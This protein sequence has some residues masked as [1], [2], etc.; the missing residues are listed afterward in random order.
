MAFIVQ[1]G[2]DIKEGKTGEFVEW[3]N[4][5]EK[6]L[7][8]AHPAGTKYLGTFFAIYTSEKTAGNAH[9][10]VEME[11]YGSQDALA[12]AGK[13]PDSLYGKLVN[14][15]VSF[16]DQSSNN[17]TQALYKRATAATLWGED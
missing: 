8:N 2:G 11:N 10:F 13:D 7:A 6:E 12:A 5:N 16:Y 9:T 1:F 17:W 15:M 4:S 14:E 3:L